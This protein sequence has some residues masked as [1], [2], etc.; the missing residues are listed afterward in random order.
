MYELAVH[1]TGGDLVISN[2]ANY[3]IIGISGL[4]PVNAQINSSMISGG[5]GAM[6]NS[7]H[8]GTRNIVLTI[9]PNYPV[10]VNRQ[11][12]Y[13]AFGVKNKITIEYRTET[14]QVQIDGYVEYVQADL[15]AQRQKIQISIICMQPYFKSAQEIINDLSSIVGMFEFPFALEEEGAV[16]SEL[17]IVRSAAVTNAGDVPCGAIF[18]MYAT[19]RVLNPVIYNAD[20]ATRFAIN[21]E[22]QQGDEIIIDTQRGSK[23]MTLIRDG[24]RLNII[25]N[26]AANI[27]WFQLPVGETTFTF[28]ADDGTEEN[29]T[30]S[31]GH[32]NLFGGV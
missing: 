23:S 2:N 27:T 16:F 15:F 26:R 32:Y 6:F 3:H 22:M 24:V 20:D 28:N 7:A 30:I 11:A 31:I 13:K 14:R 5:D 17:L 19:G 18:H 8:I 21:I 4:T 1:S 9:L 10:D 12:L 25:N 29:L